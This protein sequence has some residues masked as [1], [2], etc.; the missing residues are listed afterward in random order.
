MKSV[1]YRVCDRSICYIFQG[2]GVVSVNDR[3]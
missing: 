2:W 1:E 3:V